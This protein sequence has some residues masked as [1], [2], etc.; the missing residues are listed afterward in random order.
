MQRV[1]RVQMRI[2]QYVLCAVR[3]Y[4]L[5]F[6]QAR[7]MIAICGPAKDAHKGA[8]QGQ[9]TMA[10]KACLVLFQYMSDHSYPED[11]EPGGDERLDE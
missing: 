6:I 1:H 8:S 2:T 9:Q 4:Y 11:L 5:G 10:D 3:M 7:L